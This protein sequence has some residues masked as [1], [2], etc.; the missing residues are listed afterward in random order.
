MN[1]FK[2]K[3]IRESV[4]VLTGALERIQKVFDE[5]EEARIHIPSSEEYDSERDKQ[6][7]ILEK[8]LSALSGLE[9]AIDSLKEAGFCDA[10][11]VKAE[12][13][14]A[15]VEAPVAPAPAKPAK[16][17][18]IGCLGWIF[19]ITLPLIFAGPLTGLLYFSYKN[20][21]DPIYLLAV[22]PIFIIYIFLVRALANSFEKPL[23]LPRPQSNTYFTPTYQDDGE[24]ID[25]DAEQADIFM[26]GLVGGY[27][28]DKALNKNRK[29]FS[30][31][32]HDEIFW[33]EKY[34]QH[35]DYHDEGDW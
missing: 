33:Q 16:K 23:Y 18:G 25:R 3:R 10:P 24:S 32:W 11:A 20:G 9:V 35:D 4:L 22:I 27:F 34:R 14:P 17:E 7:E 29:S 5:E 30:D 21:E 15:A 19:A 2:R 13:A 6:D 12:S 8:L 1:G 26:G 31:K 28:L